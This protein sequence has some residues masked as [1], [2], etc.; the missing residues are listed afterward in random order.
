[1]APKR[2]YAVA[3]GRNPGIYTTWNEAEK[4]VNGFS[5]ARHRK[6]SNEQDAIDWFHEHTDYP[7]DEQDVDDYSEEASGSRASASPSDE[8]AGDDNSQTVFAS[9][10]SEEE[11][12][13]P[14]N[15]ELAAQ[16]GGAGGAESLPSPPS[17]GK[18]VRRAGKGH[19]GGGR[20]TGGCRGVI[21]VH[22]PPEKDTFWDSHTR[23]RH[24][25]GL[26]G[27]MKRLS[28]ETI[29]KTC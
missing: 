28:I 6:F 8:N 4:Q 20:G 21:S 5:G 18:P 17:E 27:D 1:M 9:E 26:I 11:S 3:A 19:G 14:E 22:K 12:P 2:Y 15:A 29:V 13:G 23:C 10:S 24:E 16:A 7:S 25:H